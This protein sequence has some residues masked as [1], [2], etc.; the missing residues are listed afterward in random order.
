LERERTAPLRRIEKHARREAYQGAILDSEY[1]AVDVSSSSL[2]HVNG[3]VETPNS[4]SQVTA[5]AG[6][7][8]KR[9]GG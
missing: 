3:V 9:E 2:V 1:K 7:E 4:G 8:Q 6:G 5:F